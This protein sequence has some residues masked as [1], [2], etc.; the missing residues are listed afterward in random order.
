MT[1]FPDLRFLNVSTT[2]DCFVAGATLLKIRKPNGVEIWLLLGDYNQAC[3]N[4]STLEGVAKRNALMQHNRKRTSG[5]PGDFTLYN[6]E[7]S[8]IRSSHDDNRYYIWLDEE[9]FFF[10]SDLDSEANEDDDDDEWV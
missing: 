2:T 1:Q 9:D 10:F 5:G 4:I 7:W 3:E 8:W 6:E